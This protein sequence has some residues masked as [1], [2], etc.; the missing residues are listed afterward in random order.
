MA[1]K[2]FRTFGLLGLCT[3]MAV[4]AP[5][6]SLADEAP[7]SEDTAAEAV[8]AEADGTG[9]D[10]LVRVDDMETDLYAE[11]DDEAQVVGQA[12][13]G[14]T[15][16]V[17]ELVDDAWMKISTGEA[18]GYINTVKTA[19]TVAEPV[20]EEVVV[21]DSARLRQEI[22][23][24]GL[25]FVGNRYVYG[26]TD[27]NRGADCSGFT[28]YVLRNAAGVELP[29]SSAAQSRCGRTISAE[30]M[31]PGDLIC[32]SSGKRINHV[33][34]YIGDGLIVHASN[35]RTGIKVSEWNYRKPARIVNVLGD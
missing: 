20:V 11:P 28:S 3:M 33:A 23:D 10:M 29:H 31:R 2:L 4:S 22:A 16:T 19:A 15:Y 25:Q 18:E 27:P 8:T 21:D 35:E 7:K 30:E 17:L 6:V 5:M 32:Y 26:G 34:L 13:T 9:P 14:S 1:N 24:Y 12:E